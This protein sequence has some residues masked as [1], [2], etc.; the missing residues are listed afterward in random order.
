M[1]ICPECGERKKFTASLERSQFYTADMDGE[2]EEI[3]YDSINDNELNDGDEQI[4]DI[5]CKTCD[6]EKPEQFE[7]EIELAKYRWEHTDKKGEWHKEELPEEE[8]D[9]KIMLEAGLNAL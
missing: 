6:C 7:E 3:N 4:N 1:Y 2:D 5:T 8:R 9:A